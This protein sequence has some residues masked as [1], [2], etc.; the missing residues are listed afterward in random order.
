MA[1]RVRFKT[2]DGTIV[3]FTKK[4]SKGRGGRVGPKGKKGRFELWSIH[5]G[6]DREVRRWKGSSEDAAMTK[7]RE[8]RRIHGWLLDLLRVEGDR[9]FHLH[10]FG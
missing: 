1:K 2:K 5:D 4:K 8:L 9:K 6:G 7:G 3:S 10:T